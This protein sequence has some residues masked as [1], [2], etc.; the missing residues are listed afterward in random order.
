MVFL[1]TL[2]GLTISVADSP[3]SSAVPSTFSVIFLLVF[4]WLSNV[5]GLVGT[6]APGTSGLVEIELLRREAE[7][8]V[9]Y[10]PVFPADVFPG[11]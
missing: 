2:L 4:D 5:T 11:R 10:D 7:A 6:P 8:K 1:S 9:L 3:P